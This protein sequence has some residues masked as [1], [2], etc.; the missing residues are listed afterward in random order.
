MKYRIKITTFSNG[1]QEYCAHVRKCFIWTG[2]ASDGEVGYAIRFND[3]D[4][5]LGA[6]DLHFKG[7]YKKQSIRFEYMTYKN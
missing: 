7:N 3:R 6:I 4:R 2:L 5:A 1:R